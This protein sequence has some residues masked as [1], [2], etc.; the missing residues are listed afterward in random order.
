LDL[1]AESWAVRVAAITKVQK[2]K[3]NSCLVV[4]ESPLYSCKTTLHVADFFPSNE[5]NTKKAPL[6]LLLI[7][8]RHS[9]AL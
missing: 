7:E 9:K 4:K 8:K 6:Y 2:L 3:A 1:D 5:G